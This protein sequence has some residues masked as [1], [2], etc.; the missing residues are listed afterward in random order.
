MSV[1]ITSDYSSTL[2]LFNQYL[3][4]TDRLV[5]VAHW[6]GEVMRKVRNVRDEEIKKLR[7]IEEE[8]KAEER[9]LA[10]EKIKKDERGA[11]PP[12]HDGRRAAQVP[13]PR[14][15][16]GPAQVNEEVQPQGLRGA[17]DLWI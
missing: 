17:E 4:L 16:E 5:Q 2:P 8:E 14:E 7:R 15:P 13:E 6:R 10:A 3:R 1:S 9:K 12:W 11:S